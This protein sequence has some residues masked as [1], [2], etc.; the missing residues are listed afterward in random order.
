MILMSLLKSMLKIRLVEEYFAEKLTSREIR[1]PVHLYVGQE[2]IA[3]GVCQNLRTDDYVL[4]THRSHGHY[5]AKG[6]DV[7]ALVAE[8]FCKENGCSHGYGG[9]MHIVDP[10]IN[11]LASSAIVAGSIPI[12]AGTGLASK[13]KNEDRVSVAF[14][15]DGATDEG[16]FWETV[17]V[18]ALLELPVLFVCENNLFSTHMPIAL[19]QAEIDIHKKVSAFGLETARIEGNDVEKVYTTARG[20][21]ERIRATR[22]PALLECLTFRWL[23]HVGPDPDLDIGYRKKVDVEKW[24]KKCPIQG[25]KNRLL[26][27]GILSEPEYGRLVGEIETLVGDADRFRRAGRDPSVTEF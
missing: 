19:R 1:C 12:A 23:A 13:L 9:S 26:E 10:K 15:G 2:G 14:F 25:L 11:Y 3:A 7:N 4:S 27:R 21:I 16:V 8:V 6:G 22:K 18:A 5:I 20:L 24:R 17:N